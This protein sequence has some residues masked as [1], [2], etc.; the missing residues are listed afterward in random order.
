MCPDRKR[1]LCFSLLLWLAWAPLTAL[2]LEAASAGETWLAQTGITNGLCV[3]PGDAKCSLALKLA[4]RTDFLFYV[5]LPTAAET[6]SAR[7]AA[8]D[9]GLYGTRI[10]VEQGPPASLSLAANLADVL[11]AQKDTALTESEALRVLRPGGRL[12][13]NQKAA[14]KPFPAGIDDW[15]HPYHGPDN[16]PVSQ[17]RV[18][19][20]PYLTQFL[21]DPRYAPLPQLA[22]ASAGRVFKAFGHIAFKPRE[23]PWLN[24]LAAFNGYNGTLL[25]R[26]EIT[27][28][29]MVHRNILVATPD[30]LFF[31]DDKSC[32]V[33]DAATG[34]L[35]TQIAPPPETVGGTFWKWLALE[36]GVLY[37]LIGEAEP[38]DPTI[39]AQRDTHGWP[40]TPLSPGYNAPE[41]PWGFGQTLVAIDAKTKQLLWKYRESQPIDSRALCLNHGRFFAYRPGAYLACI[42]TRSGALLWRKTRE[43]APDL[44]E[45]IGSPLNRQDWRTNFRTTA[46]LKCTDQALYFAGPTIG[47][48]LA[49]SA[50][51]GQ[52]MW[53]HPYDNY[54][55]LV[56]PDAIYGI[57][58]MIDKDPSRKFDP[59]TGKVLAEIVV[60]RRS[61]TRPTASPDAIFFR[62]GEGS[63]RI[64][65]SRDQPEIVSPMRAQCHDGVTIAN[66]L[67]YWWPSTCDCNLSLYGITCLGPAESFNFKPDATAADRLE[68]GPAYAESPKRQSQTP[69]PQDWPT[70]RA[71]TFASA[72]SPVK[73]SASAKPLWTYTP[74]FSS[75]PSAPTTAGDLIF[76]GESHGTVRALNARS[77][78][79]AWSAFTGGNV[80]YPPTLHRSQAL[81]ASADGWV[82]NFE[83][84]SGKLRWRF[85]AA[86]AER[87]IPVYGQLQSTWPAASG[88]AVEDGVAYV[89]A[90]IANYDGT[91][92]YALD[93][94]T[95]KLRWQNNSSGHLD[96]AARTGVS[97]QGHLLIYRDKLYLA[98]GNAVSP[99]VYT[100]ASGQCLNDPAQLKRTIRNNLVGAMDPRGCE[101]YL[102]QDQIKVGGR[103]LYAHPQYPVIDPTVQN[104]VLYVPRDDCDIAWAHHANSSKLI[105][106]PKITGDRA[107]K[108]LQGWGKPTIPDVKPRWTFDCA[109]S[110]AFA[111]CPNALLVATATE[112][113][114]VAPETG[115]VLWKHPLPA[116]PV[117]W[118]IAVNRDGKIIVTLEGGMVICFG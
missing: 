111:A 106:Y 60:G 47:K 10:F 16:N 114:A 18:A 77:G 43:N 104:R 46:Y 88:V 118:G 113:T 75:T 56:Y 37:A 97:V 62:A 102:V 42:D 38:L 108:L 26:H 51:T 81:V 3:L 19:R 5:Q 55:L 61:C 1:V 107:A 96:P 29:L 95:G 57:S 80:H 74:K 36:N 109:G 82:Y 117:P 44:F 50:A 79:L 116:A 99:G 21:S 11:L 14:T 8:A 89:A 86:P 28:G 83:A 49:V 20:G 35:K 41:H 32:K 70:F 33:Y 65:V 72:T 85:R 53:S 64:D 76:L 6:A 68:R 112:L 7:Q 105:A 54:Q 94:D 84:A 63:T 103:P 23:E 15:S 52:V 12:W 17:D 100:L 66:G 91:Y 115:T 58:G 31:A 67:L 78:K 48:L 30:E 13:L 4:A 40:W 34:V 69:H 59:L 92:V 98:G 39:K 25:W 9:A 2:R 87:K 45:Q 110:L 73:I 22:V 93:A 27:P 90:G 24:T 101:L 71:D